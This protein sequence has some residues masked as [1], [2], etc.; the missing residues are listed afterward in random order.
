M[1][2]FKNMYYVWGKL[3]TMDF[4]KGYKSVSYADLTK[5]LNKAFASSGKGYP[6]LAVAASVTSTQT[7]K[8]AFDED[9]QKV[10]DK[11]LS[12]IFQAINFQ[13]FILW[14]NGE[15]MYFLKSKN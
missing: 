1:I 3:Q 11:V 4:I 8:F 9:S 12:S 7:I 13:A 14:I 2:E 5:A 15:R 6:D 10:S